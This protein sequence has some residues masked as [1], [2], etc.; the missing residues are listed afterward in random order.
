L[1]TTAY[2]LPGCQLAKDRLVVAARKQKYKF[3]MAAAKPEV[4]VSQLLY[5]IAKKFQR[6]THVFGVG[7]SMALLVML[8]L[9]TGSEKFKMAAAK[10]EVPVS[11]LLYKIAKKF[12]RLS[13]CFRGRENA[14]FN[15]KR[16][17]SGSE[18]IE[19]EVI[20]P[21][22]GHWKVNIQKLTSLNLSVKHENYDA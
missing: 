17:G 15:S 22:P 11:Q 18:K 20:L 13:A 1:T 10:P 19:L 21:P 8:Y 6:L 16:F 14:P 9:E 5:K 4:P 3:K 7:N 2:L 12:Q